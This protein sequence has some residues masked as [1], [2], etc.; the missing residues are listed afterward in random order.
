MLKVLTIGTEQKLFQEGSVARAR[1]LSYGSLVDELY[2]IAFTKASDGFTSFS[3]GNTH[4]YPTGSFSKLLAPYDAW[5]IALTLKGKGINLVSAQDPFECGLA[6][7]FSAHALKAKLHI[8]IHT[9]FLSPFFAR[10][11][12]L[13]RLRVF[14]GLKIISRADCIRVVSARIVRSLI[15]RGVKTRSTPIVLPV[16]VEMTTQNG[17]S[18]FLK[19]KYPAFSR[20]LLVASRLEPEKNVL[21]AVESFAKLRKNFNDTAL[22]IVGDGS[23]RALLTRRAV[24]LGIKDSVFFEGWRKNLTPYY[25]SASLFLSTSD[26]EGYG[27]SSVEA[28]IAGLSLLS[29]DAGI[30]SELYEV[31]AI[32]IVPPRDSE[33][34]AKALAWTLEN[35]P[36]AKEEATLAREKA[37]SSLI[38][39]EEYLKRYK[40]AWEECL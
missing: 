11:S 25:E 35:L 38:S 6:G 40:L 21:M 12:I 14:I 39:Q 37:L 22:V 24:A 3:I 20:F 29:T 34:F 18:T 15:S 16:Y 9:D 10:G 26:Y 23:Q 4:V 7:L 17:S 13:N 19:E 32:N 5:R 2:I 30:I 1:I 33:S 27:M 31:G 36:R 8:Q 28:L